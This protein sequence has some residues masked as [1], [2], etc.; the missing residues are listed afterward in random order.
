MFIHVATLYSVQPEAADAFVRSIR[1]DGD[2]QRLARRV[3]PDL[4]VSD[5][6]QHQS[7]SSPV[8]LCIDFW[9]SREKYLRARKSGVYD[10]LL[11]MRSRLA[12]ATID[13][14]AFMFPTSAE[15][16]AGIPQIADLLIG[17]EFRGSR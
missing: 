15:P 17:T 14:G 12:A 8:F 11:N 3:A 4:V 13:L 10:H 5:L 1:A 2:W 6:L 16:D 7:S 9:A